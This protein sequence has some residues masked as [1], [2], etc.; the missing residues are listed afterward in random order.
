MRLRWGQ[1]K[2]ELKAFRQEIHDFLTE[3]LTESEIFRRLKAKGLKGDKATFHR[4]IKHLKAEQPAALPALASKARPPKV[5][6]QRSPTSSQELIP[7]GNQRGAN[8][9]T[10]LSVVAAEPVPEEESQPRGFSQL[11][12]AGFRKRTFTADEIF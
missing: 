6:D 1:G 3:G 2:I 5:S 12:Q 4:A 8:L 11:E 7:P 9:H 10:S